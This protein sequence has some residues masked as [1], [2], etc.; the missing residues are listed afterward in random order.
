[1]PSEVVEMTTDDVSNAGKE[2]TP[3]PS[4]KPVTIADVSKAISYINRGIELNQPRLLQ[5]AIRQNANLR[6]NITTELLKTAINTFVTPSYPSYA[7]MIEAISKLPTVQIRNAGNEAETAMDVISDTITP[8]SHALLPETEVY[9]FTLIITTMLRH[10]LYQDTAAYS[11]I[12]I[13]RI[14]TFN[15]RSMDLFSSKAYFYFSLAYEKIDKLEAVRSTLL[16]LYR[17]SCL[18]RDEMGQAV[19]LNLI[20]RNYLHYNLIEQAQTLAAKTTFPENASNNQFCRYLYSMG[21]IQ[22][23]QLEY[24]GAYLRLMMSARKAPQDIALGF[25]RS[26]YKLAVLVQLLMGD[27]PERATFNQPELRKALRPYLLLTQTVRNGDLVEFHAVV[28]QHSNAFQSDKNYSLVQRLGH[29]VVKTGLRKISISY[30]CISLSDVAMKL[31]LPSASS[32]EYICAKAIRDG[33]IEATID[34]KSGC[35]TSN[36]VI[37]VYST[38]EPQKAFHRRIAF[39]LDVHNEAVKSMRYPPDAYKKELAL[40]SNPQPD[41]KTVEELVKE[42]E[43]DMDDL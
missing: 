1:M 9:L 19:L 33:V 37:D 24:S 16:S 18:R 2:N 40:A 41:D 6:H 11:S 36:E 29:N 4:P 14:K 10:K 43:D 21:R 15:R 17:T 32:A 8:S 26:V 34:H 7:T 39:C 31:H 22:A 30:S 3:K 42:L 12:L 27:I 38:E 13:N 35:L 25:T 20:L 23:I 28:T 5:R